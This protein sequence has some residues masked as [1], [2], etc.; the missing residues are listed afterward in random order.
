[1]SVISVF[2]LQHSKGRASAA[3]AVVLEELLISSRADCVVAVLM[4][5][6]LL[7]YCVIASEL[8]SKYELW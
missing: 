7:V 5:S 6:W 4:T 8:D 3:A 2:V 1:M